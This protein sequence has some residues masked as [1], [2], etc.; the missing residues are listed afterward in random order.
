MIFFFF[1][2][3]FLLVASGEEEGKDN[4][5]IGRYRSGYGTTFS[6]T[7]VAITWAENTA[8]IPV[9]DGM[10]DMNAKDHVH[11]VVALYAADN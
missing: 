5:V 6:G 11:K 1:G 7:G 2:P 8:Q 10:P 3:S 4:L 9:P